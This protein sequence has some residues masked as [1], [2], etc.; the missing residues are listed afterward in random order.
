MVG[1]NRPLSAAAPMASAYMNSKLPPKLFLLNKESVLLHCSFP[2][3]SNCSKHSLIQ[4]KYKF[5]DFIT[6]DRWMI[7]NIHE[8]Y[9]VK[10]SYQEI[11][12]FAKS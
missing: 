4:A 3:W 1:R 5:W 2:Y 11:R 7:S 6:S 8:K 9:M 10:I 12:P